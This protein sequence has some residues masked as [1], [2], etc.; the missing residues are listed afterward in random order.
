MKPR[1]A[2]LMGG[3]SLERD[4]SWKSGQRVARALKERGYQVLELD[5]DEELVPTLMSEKPDLVYISLHG[6]GGEDGTVQELL[7]ILGIPYTGPGL[8]SS[9]IG[10]N[11]ILSKELFLANGITTPR[12]C[13]VSSSTLKEMGASSLLPVVYEKLGFP[14]VVKPA[15]QGSALGLTIVKERSELGP[16]LIEA[17][18]YDDRALIEEF[19]TGAE[20]AISIVGND[21][22]EALPAIEVVPESGL[23]DFSARYTPGKTK[24]FVPAR[25]SDEVAAEASRL[26]LKAH[27]LFRC[28]DVSRVDMIVKDEK[29]FVLEL[30]ISPGMTETS[31]LP[32][33][34]QAAGLDFCDLVEKLAHLALEKRN[35]GA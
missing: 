4:V 26:A 21:P 33:A 8:L 32:L 3:R 7:E 23:F 12:Y 29:P 9:I 10:F 5:V 16:A 18:S 31:L 30:N 35:T 11:K 34:A 2:V 15:A 14:L 1:I 19:V 27:N 24:Y 25:L 17:L 13:V 6:K 20:I 22:P 28:K